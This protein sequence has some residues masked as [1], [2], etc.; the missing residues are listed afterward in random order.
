MT[1][2]TRKEISF[3]WD[4]KCEQ[5][6]MSLKERLTIAHVLIISGPSKSYEV[7]CD[8]SK[9]GLGGVLMQGGQVVA[10][11]SHQLKTHEE[12]YPTH[13]LELEAY[14]FTLKVWHHY[15]YGVCF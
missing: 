14:V 2:L 6:F 12:N 9:K 3:S 7:F 13:D 15:W 4:S 8:A 11:A 5:S 1:R 10:Y